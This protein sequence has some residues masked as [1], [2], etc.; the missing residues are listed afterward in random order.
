MK[1]HL[2]FISI[3]MTC[4]LMVSNGSAQEVKLAFDLV[5]GSDRSS[6]HSLTVFN[7]KLYFIAYSSKIS[8][9]PFFNAD[10]K[11][12]VF[13][14]NNRPKILA[15]IY[16]SCDH[17]SWCY[18]P[19]PFHLD[20]GIFKNRLY[21][22]ANDGTH[23]MELWS[24]D[25]I[26]EPAMEA[27]IYT[28]IGHSVPYGF[29]VFKNKLYFNA[30]S[31]FDC[32]GLDYCTSDDELWEY[33][34]VNPPQRVADIIPGTFTGSCP[35][36]LTVYKGKLYFTASSK[37][38]YDYEIDE[39][40]LL[41]NELWVYDGEN[42]PSEVADI[43]PGIWDSCPTNLTVY[44]KKLYFYAS[45]ELYRRQLWVYNGIS[46]PEIVMDVVPENDG[47]S[48]N[49]IT[50]FKNKLFFG[51]SDGIH[52]M[53]L[54]V[55][56]GVNPPSMV[57]DIHKGCGSSYP[58]GFYNY[59]TTVFKDKLYF[60][61]DDGKHGYEL[62]VYDGNSPPSLVADIYR[63]KKS[64]YPCGFSEYSGK[65]YFSADDGVHGREVWELTA[66]DPDQPPSVSFI[67]PTNGSTVCGM[68]SVKVN[69]TDDNGISQV[70][71][72]I[73]GELKHTV[74][75]ASF[76]D[77][78]GYT[79]EPFSDSNK[80]QYRGKTLSF[81]NRDKTA[82]KNTF[83]YEWDTTAYEIGNHPVGVIV[84][85]TSGQKGTARVDVTVK[86]TFPIHVLRY[87]EKAWIIK[88]QYGKLVLDVKDTRSNTTAK[89]VI[90]RKVDGGAYQSIKEI[91][92]SEL[93]TGSFTYFDKYLEKD[94]TYTYKA[95]AYNSL[96]KVIA[97]SGEQ[98]I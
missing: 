63:G 48:P 85:D 45:N 81:V 1:K 66:E 67:S 40:Y 83:I 14:G 35:T 91:P 32:D 95:E 61:A 50:C 79:K 23:G 7:G 10:S 46:S 43:N 68:V 52:G 64:S 47:Y 37:D 57:A 76:S 89:Y 51:A 44:K 70:N 13:D 2:I 96:G 62:W 56:D 92:A 77:E 94:K 71:F 97:V 59:T 17:N 6:P 86:N 28:G 55:Y 98:T 20:F 21:F 9:E 72:Y 42:P 82:I 65:L 8:Y 38:E 27:D 12:W 54:W 11:V 78:S 75:P 58:G 87:T 33:D 31:S 80:I 3:F 39:V 49:G 19:P 15:E 24:Y 53:E 74:K 22:A 41:D 90:Y 69:A 93:Q 73:D 25:G 36:N 16:F 84:Y 4:L 5:S 34:G 60:C 26:N 29:T 30:T 18:C 88:K